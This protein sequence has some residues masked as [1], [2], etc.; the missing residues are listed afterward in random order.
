MN[1]NPRFRLGGAVHL[2][3]SI[4][5]L[6]TLRVGLILLAFGLGV[7]APVPDAVALLSIA[8]GAIMAVTALVLI[9]RQLRHARR[10]VSAEL[11]QN[12]GALDRLTSPNGQHQ[13]VHYERLD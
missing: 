1:D 3:R 2:L 4:A 9:W 7:L 8:V 12:Q 10:A 6:V 11:R 5:Q 13:T